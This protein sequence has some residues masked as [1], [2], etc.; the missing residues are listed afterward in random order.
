MRGL[1]PR[2]LPYTHLP[3]IKFPGQSEDDKSLSS[4][5]EIKDHFEKIPSLRYAF[6]QTYGTTPLP[7]A[8]NPKC[9]DL[10]MTDNDSCL[11]CF[12]NSF[13]CPIKWMIA[14]STEFQP[15]VPQKLDFLLIHILRHISPGPTF[16]GLAL[17]LSLFPKFCDYYI[18]HKGP[19][20]KP[21]YMQGVIG[22]FLSEVKALDKSAKYF[23]FGRPRGGPF[24]G[25]RV[26]RSNCL[27]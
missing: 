18:K 9:L 15:C 5:T 11:L 1:T 3:E 27:D 6:T 17:L 21:D 16:D 22:T 25:P 24:V 19:Q 13:T 26:Q 23:D 12:Y 14:F 8:L 2:P 20:E 10:T 7:S 4:Y